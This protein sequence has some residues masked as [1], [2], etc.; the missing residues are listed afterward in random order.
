MSVRKVELVTTLAAI[1]LAACASTSLQDDSRA[2]AKVEPTQGNAARGMVTFAQRADRVVITANIT[3]LPPNS[4]HGFHVHERG[5]CSAPDASSAG[6]HFNPFRMPHGSHMATERH[7]GDM[8][9]LSADAKGNARYRAE[10]ST[11]NVASGSG[12][13]V[14]KS[15]VIHRDPDDYQSQP[16]GNA[17]ARIAC[18]VI[19][20][21][22]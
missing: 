19:E 3:G 22:S 10:L 14:D 1:V 11:M 13:I 21:V 17:G 6:D 20:P 12:A 9:N 18:G 7:V 5:D 4:E 16:S 2:A 8:P 15:V